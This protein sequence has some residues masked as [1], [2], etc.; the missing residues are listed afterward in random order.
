MTFSPIIMYSI[1]FLTAFIQL[2]NATTP[3]LWRRDHF[4]RVSIGDNEDLR[5]PPQAG[6]ASKIT[7]S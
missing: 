4:F 1:Y 6:S 5:P 7:R 3:A 2:N